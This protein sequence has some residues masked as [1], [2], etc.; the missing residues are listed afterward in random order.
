[1]PDDNN[2]MIQAGFIQPGQQQP[3]SPSQFVQA[4]QFAQPQPQPPQQF[5][6]PPQVQQASVAQ[7]SATTDGSTTVAPTAVVTGNNNSI[8]ISSIVQ[9]NSGGLSSMRILMLLWGVGV[10]LMWSGAWIV[11]LVH[12][13][14]LAPTIPSEIVTILLGLTGVKC[15]QRFGEK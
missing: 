4:P 10:F 7:T 1:M 13:I 8:D 2:A 9:D 5:Q 6:Q 14:Y 12:G 15:V 3:Q 11:G